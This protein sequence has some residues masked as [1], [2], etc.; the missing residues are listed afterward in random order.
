M[1]LLLFF[2]TTMQ[3]KCTVY[4][5]NKWYKWWM[6]LCLF[7][8][9]CV[10]LVSSNVVYVLLYYMLND[11]PLSRKWFCDSVILLSQGGKQPTGDSIVVC[12]N[13][14]LDSWGILFSRTN[15][16]KQQTRYSCK[17]LGLRNY[18]EMVDFVLRSSGILRLTFP[19][20]NIIVL[21]FTFWVFVIYLTGSQKSG[22]L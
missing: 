7:W 14:Y 22:L 17:L 19:Y 21:H 16:Y 12:F 15:M 8:L 3:V 5:T 18:V 4:L 6:F 20:F 2:C 10:L 13:C 11:P 9:C 1:C